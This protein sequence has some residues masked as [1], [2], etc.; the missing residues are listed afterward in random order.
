LS[1]KV[2]NEMLEV[3]MEEHRCEPS[4]NL[5]LILDLF[6]ILPAHHLHRVGIWCQKVA[7]V[8]SADAAL[9]DED[10]DLY[11]G[12]NGDELAPANSGAD[13][14]ADAAEESFISRLTLI[15]AIFPMVILSF[16]V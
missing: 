16:F 5:I 7:V 13:T 6:A 9:D 10:T 1:G 8:D 11:K 3:T 15:N 12:N 4:P 2:A 14:K